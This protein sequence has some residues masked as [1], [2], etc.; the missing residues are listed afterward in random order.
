MYF[1]NPKPNE[2]QNIWNLWHHNASTTAM[3]FSRNVASCHKRQQSCR[4]WA[5]NSDFC[6]N[7]FQKHPIHN[8]SGAYTIVSKFFPIVKCFNIRHG[9]TL[10]HKYIQQKDF[11]LM[12]FVLQ[13]WVTVFVNDLIH[14]SSSAIVIKGEHLSMLSIKL[15]FATKDLQ[16]LLIP[17]PIQ[18][19]TG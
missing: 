2:L 11:A 8:N 6:S 5:I 3:H 14:L 15:N 7:T 9:K 1:Y 12:Q 4:Y 13:N 19:V 17:P 16:K 18:I 10:I